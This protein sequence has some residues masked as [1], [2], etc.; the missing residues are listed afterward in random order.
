MIKTQASEKNKESFALHCRSAAIKA[1]AMLRES[2]FN[3]SVIDNTN[4]WEIE[5]RKDP[6]SVFNTPRKRYG[7]SDSFIRAGHGM[8]YRPAD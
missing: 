3:D 8:V 7:R 1:L 6:S 4:A 2:D 5:R